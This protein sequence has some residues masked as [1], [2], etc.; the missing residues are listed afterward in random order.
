MKPFIL[1]GAVAIMC[2]VFIM[3][4]YYRLSHAK[5]LIEIHSPAD[6]LAL[7]P[8]STQEIITRTQKAMDDLRMQRATFLAI[9]AEKR[10]FENTAHAYDYM[11]AASDL[12]TLQSLWQATEMIHPDKGMREAA[13]EQSLLITNFMIDELH[14]SDAVYEAWQAYAQGNGQQESLSDS[15]RY[16]VNHVTK[17][18]KRNGLQLPREQREKL[19]LIQKDLAKV[20]LEFGAAIAQSNPT[21]AVTQAELEGMSADFIAALKKDEKGNYLL[22]TDYPTYIPVVRECHNQETRKR[23]LE[24]FQNRAYPENKTRL[25][26]IIALRDEIGK[27]LGYNSYAEYELA[28][29]MVG[30]V[31]HAQKFLTDLLKS[32]QEKEALEIATLFSRDIKNITYRTDGKIFPWDGAYLTTQYKKQVFHLDE[33]EVAAYFP[34]EK[35]VAGLLDIYQQFFGLKFEQIRGQKFWSDDVT[36]LAVRPKDSNQVLGYLLLDLYPRENKY[37]HACQATMVP[38]IF[39]SNGKPN[40]AVLMVIANF[41]KSTPQ[42]PSLL[43]YKDVSTFFHEFGHAMHALLGRTHQATFSGTSTKLDFVELP[44]QMLEEWLYDPAI[45][46]KVSSHYQTGEP[47][48]DTLINTLI[49]LKNFSSGSFVTGQCSLAFLALDYYG[50]GAIKDLDAILRTVYEQAQKFSVFMPQNHFYAS[51]GH[52]REYAA[53]YYGYLWSKVFALDIFEQIKK[54]GLLNPVVGHRYAQTILARGGSKDP[55]ELLRE[56]L[57]REPNQEAFLKDLGLQP[58]KATAIPVVDESLAMAQQ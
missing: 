10:T 6:V 9:P 4:F 57:G 35:T 31:A 47:L 21:I 11:A 38:S 42:R 56:F 18:F 23:L 5:P 27:L 39:Y 7:F 15:Q 50:A 40:I 32:G 48:P 22:G 3:I 29:Q 43:K 1:T 49:E 14:M 33:E 19:K 53:R 16:F 37:N 17:E 52:L 8:Q 2:G 58:T 45:L 36:M 26:R 20:S 24:I 13:H 44:S 30:S 51:F 54:E 28:D 41:P 34:M 55:N 12:A 25:E 46:K